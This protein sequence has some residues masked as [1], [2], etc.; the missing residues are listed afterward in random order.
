MFY[1]FLVGFYEAEGFCFD[2]KRSFESVANFSGRLIYTKW[3]EVWDLLLRADYD[4][5]KSK[6]RK[7]FLITRGFLK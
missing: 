1:V 5:F 4:A 7:K 2:W 3:H 6:A